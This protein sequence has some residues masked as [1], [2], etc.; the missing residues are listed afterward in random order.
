MKLAVSPAFAL[1]F[2][3]V[4]FAHAATPGVRHVDPNQPVGRNA[5][6]PFDATQQPTR[7]AS[8]L[9]HDPTR[10]VIKLKPQT[11]SKKRTT[12][13]SADA[14]AD[15]P[16]LGELK[17]IF[18]ASSPSVRA[19]RSTGTSSATDPAE[20]DLQLWV[21]A[22]IA[23]GTDVPQLLESLQQN[24]AVDVAEPD[25]LYRLDA[26]D[27]QNTLGSVGTTSPRQLSTSAAIPDGSADPLMATQWHLDAAK[28]K[29][30]WSYLQGQGLPAGG[31]RDVII[32]VIDSGVDYTHPDLAANMWVNGREIP[33]NGIDDDGNGFVDD[34]HGVSFIGSSF[35]HRGN[36]MD[37][38]GHGTHVAGIIAAAANNGIGG[39][40]IAYNCQIM[41]LKAAQYSGVLS[42]VDIAE[43][44]NYAVAQGADVINMS[45]GGPATSTLIE[46]ALAVAFS[47]AV[48]VA[49]AGNSGRQTESPP[50]TPAPMPNFPASYIYVLGTMAQLQAPNAWG[51]WL[52]DFSNW[53]SIPNSRIEYELMAP[54]VAIPSTLPGAQYAAWSGTSM[55]APVVSGIAALVRTKFPDKDLYSSR[56]IMGQLASV[57]P[58][59]PG[60][61][62]ILYYSSDALQA[63]AST[64]EP[65]LTFLDYWIFDGPNI[66]AGNN[67]NGII[68]AGETID[69]AVVIKNRWGKADP[70]TVKIAAQAPGAVGPSPY[71]TWINDTVDYG[72]V[73]SFG[74]DDNGLIYED[75]LITGVRFPFKFTVSADCP[76]DYIIPFE[77]T[78]TCGNGFDPSDPEAP[79]T[80]TARFEAVVQKGRVLPSV[81]TSDLTMGPDVYWI[82]DGPVLIPSGVEVSVQPGTQI[83]FWSADPKEPYSSK[84]W[85]YLQ[86]EGRFTVA[87][88]AT[89]PVEIFP[90]SFHPEKSVSIFESAG[91]TVTLDYFKL[92]NPFIG[93]RVGYSPSY[94]GSFSH[95]SHGLVTQS[96]VWTPEGFHSIAAY[97]N[98]R[99]A[100]YIRFYRLG[101]SDRFSYNAQ[102]PSA[103][104]NFQVYGGNVCLFDSCSFTLD[105]QQSVSN[106]VFLNNYTVHYSS[107]SN[108][109]LIL[110][111]LLFLRDTGSFANGN[112]ILNQWWRPDFWKRLYILAPSGAGT[113]DFG[114]T[115]FGASP[116]VV[117]K[118]ILDNQDDFNLMRVVTSPTAAPPANAWPFVVDCA[119]T[120]SAGTRAT[121]VGAEAVTFTVTF[122]RDM[123]TT[124]APRVTFGPDTPLADYSVNPINGGWQD[125]RTWVGTFNITPITGDGYQ[126]IKITDAV[127]ADDPWLVNGNDEG[128]FRFEIVTSG[129]EAL[130]LQASGG[131]GRIDLSWTQTDFELL[132][133]YNLYR[134]TTEDGS[135]TRVNSSIIPAQTKQFVDVNVQ[136][137]QPYFYKFTVVQTDMSESAPSN[138][139]QATPRDTIAPVIAH[140]PLTQA[141]PNLSLPI[142]AD[143]TDNVAVTGATIFYR[144]QGQLTYQSRAMVKISG[145]RWTVSLEGSKV[146]A[147]G[148]EYYLS[149][150]DGVSATLAGRPETPYLIRVEDRPVVT[151]VSPSQGQVVGGT[152]VTIT[153]TNFKAGAKVFFGSTAATNVVVVSANQ[154]TCAT[155]VN[156][157]SKVSVRV[158]NQDGSFSTLLNAFTFIDTTPTLYVPDSSTFAGSG[159]TVPLSLANATG[160]VSAQITVTYDAALLRVRPPTVGPLASGWTLVA[161]TATPG[162]IVLSLA[163]GGNAAQGSGVL[164]NLPFDVIGD[165]LQSGA[166][167]IT[168]VQLN[169]GAITA[170]TINGSVTIAEGYALQGQ[171]N[172]WGD[173]GRPV[174]STLLT[175]EGNGTQ[176]ATSASDGTFRFDN[177]VN[178]AYELT[179][180]KTDQ[181]SAISAYDAALVLQHAASL[182]TLNGNPAIAAD[183]NRTGEITAMDAFRILQ[184]VAELEPLI[185]STGGEMWAFSPA[186]RLYASLTSHQTGQ[187]FSAVL[188]GDVSGNWQSVTSQ[189]GATIQAGL[190]TVP[191]EA[192]NCTHVYLLLQAG[193]SPVLGVDVVL[194]YADGRLLEACRTEPGISSAIN[195]ATAGTI[196]AALAKAEGLTGNHVLLAATFAGTA[197]PQVAV[198]SLSFNEGS[199]LAVGDPDLAA[200]DHDRDGEVDVLGLPEIKT[201][202]VS[203]TGRVGSSVS[204]TVLAAGNPEL[205]YQWQRSGTDLP[206]A[207]DRT[208]TL[209]DL[210]TG[211]AGD[212]TVRV[213]NGFGSVTS[214]PATVSVIREGSLAGWLLDYFSPSELEA[215]LVRTLSA[216]P[217]NDGFSNLLEYAMGTNPRSVTA[218]PF[219]VAATQEYWI[220][221]YSRP[222]DRT[223]A[224]YV[225]ETSTDL[226][227][228]SSTAIAHELKS[229]GVMQTWEARLPRAGTKAFFRLEVSTSTDS[230]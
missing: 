7:P 66:A 26:P 22:E 219:T 37:D 81:I 117:A 134:S 164:V 46:D 73:G 32:A 146:V 120:D 67:A 78:M 207:T 24:E 152:S 94:T 29:Q 197:D 161:N 75:G 28:V 123:N 109:N 181:V 121:R 89:S 68:N 206:G 18:A 183:V 112:A 108:K 204:L 188:R 156:I 12:A 193:P 223:D 135:Y 54:G 150:T 151:G 159:I 180:A 157:P 63:V 23:P 96:Y 116:D 86:V 226:I 34:V 125:A 131:E 155:P 30:A 173:G 56:F 186:T 222:A 93:E 137:G 102:Y 174:A 169:D 167:A 20:P 177:L 47:Q 215:A 82:I 182:G 214:A 162:R 80:F 229:E 9:D 72:A 14:L 184:H 196:R 43:A 45:F 38:Q 4:A 145:N 163:S 205:S 216:D 15:V 148:L 224:S 210:Q 172:Y 185:F 200:F 165:P 227:S 221:T 8:S 130:T 111:S 140:S 101:L 84:L 141:Q 187:D 217:D 105:S 103:Y 171:V 191:D 126:L 168:S 153:G 97:F 149:A 10:V 51:E 70:V 104:Y 124:K 139:A 58:K 19:T 1:F 136:P 50:A 90:G 87:G 36:P 55:A 27:A 198:Q 170:Q 143:I 199:I 178:A 59:L 166:L 114:E 99:Q 201:Q 194:T 61:E 98:A 128:R 118:A 228:W 49:S 3:W 5:Y 31:N 33:G 25:F 21:Q 176:T 69:L 195:T 127:A 40:G 147:P 202:P 154:I 158:E 35:D 190:A 138:I 17:P 209:D 52:A 65:E 122:N 64:P 62:G 71:I 76:N 220:F 39:V 160:L 133:G 179:P 218:P 113:F 13:S 142:S 48:L 41:A 42:S 203:Q 132:A 6:S 115:Y 85:P 79:Y 110:P 107:S 225:V 83:Q 144:T 189:S 11:A 230:P 211:N 192:G 213:T 212:Y 106:S 60:K 74:E 53:D 88:T 95:A 92:S 91:G 16:G 208:L 129:L 175:I 100:S 119:L 57:G 77:V 44:I 2:A